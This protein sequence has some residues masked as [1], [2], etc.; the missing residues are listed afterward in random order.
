MK[1]K[2]VP[3]MDCSRRRRRCWS[4]RRR[5]IVGTGVVVT[6]VPGD[7]DLAKS[8][9]VCISFLLIPKERKIVKKII[10]AR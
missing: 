6:G 10:R 8:L 1:P 4:R 3:F 5:W 9:E 7:D 2:N